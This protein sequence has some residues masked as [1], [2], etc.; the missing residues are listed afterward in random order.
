MAG[1]AGCWAS[2]KLPCRVE[3]VRWIGLDLRAWSD[4]SG[5]IQVRF[6][7]YYGE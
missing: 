3:M 5:L 6:S 2:Y 4:K 7:Q 1:R